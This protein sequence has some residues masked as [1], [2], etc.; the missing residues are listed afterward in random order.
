MNSTTLRLALAAFVLSTMTTV[1]LAEAA[2]ISGTVQS[3]DALTRTVYFT[4]G[5]VVT[6]DPGARLRV[7]D[8][9]VQ[10]SDVRPGWVLVMSDTGVAPG[11]TSSQPAP[12]VNATGVIARVDARTGT[13]TLQDGRVLRVAP[14]TTLWQP[15]PVGSLVPGA[16]VFVRNAEPLD[17]QPSATRPF[18]MGTIS[19]V[20]ASNAR[21]VLSDGTTV[22]LRPGT[23]IVSDGRSIAIGDVR[24]GDEVVVGLPAGV[25]TA[26]PSGPGV[27]ALPRSALGVVEADSLYIVSRRQAP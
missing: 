19:S 27:S 20:D 14:E 21:V 22:Y 1:G 24:V 16:Q 25:A 12:A 15:V 9:D 23:R 6:L 5:R 26:S 8:R 13:V 7:G 11:G 3:V 18:R 2:E 17:F 4:D 10:L